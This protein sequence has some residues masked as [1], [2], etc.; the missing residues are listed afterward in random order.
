V[1][2]F[3]VVLRRLGRKLKLGL[4]F[5]E[6]VLREPSLRGVEEIGPKAEAGTKLLGDGVV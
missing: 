3:C 4:S 2:F 5:R 6:M 1:S